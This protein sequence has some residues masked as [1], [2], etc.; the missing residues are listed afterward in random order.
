MSVQEREGVIYTVKVSKNI[1][2]ARIWY[3]GRD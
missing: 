3:K 2:R 1:R